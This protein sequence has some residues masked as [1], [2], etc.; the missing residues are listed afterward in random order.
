MGEINNDIVDGGF[1][2]KSRWLAFAGWFNRD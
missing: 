1:V 2:E